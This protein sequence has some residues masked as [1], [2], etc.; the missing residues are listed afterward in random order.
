MKPRHAAAFALVGWYLMLPTPRGHN[1]LRY[2][3]DLPLSKWTVFQSFDSADDCGTTLAHMLLATKKALKKIR[4]NDLDTADSSGRLA[5][6]F[7]QAE[8]I[9]TDDPRLRGN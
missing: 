4:D 2:G 8:C 1:S 3:P 5:F 7:T 9:A 6:L